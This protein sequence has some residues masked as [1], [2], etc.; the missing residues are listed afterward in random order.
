MSIQ[1]SLRNGMSWGHEGCSVTWSPMSI[2]GFSCRTGIRQGTWG[3]SVSL[4]SMSIQR[5]LL[6]QWH[7]SGDM[8]AV[9]CHLESRPST[10]SDA[11]LAS[12]KGTW[13]DV[14]STFGV[15]CPFNLFSCRNGIRH[16]DMGRCSVLGRE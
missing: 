3:C 12:G 16:G 4:E 7:Q 11:V 15:P 1:R 2:N 8:W 6:P 14:L 9:L 13:G 10:D 5:D